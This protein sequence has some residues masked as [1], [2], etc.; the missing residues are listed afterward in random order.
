L[1]ESGVLI[2]APIAFQLKF[3]FKIGDRRVISGGGFTL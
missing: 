3:G 1:I 2:I